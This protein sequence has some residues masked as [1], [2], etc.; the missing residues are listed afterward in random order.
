MSN[1]LN[2]NPWQESGP[3]FGNAYENTNNPVHPNTYQQPIHAPPQP[4]N[5]MPAYSTSG[6]NNAWGTESNKTEYPPQSAYD[7]HNMAPPPMQ[8]NAYQYT[9][10]PYGNPSHQTS[11]PSVTPHPSHHSTKPTGSV[12]PEPWTG[13]VY[14]PPSQ[15]NFWLRFV[16]LLASIG[17]LGFAAGAR[18]VIYIYSYIVI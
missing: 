3:R 4:S 17:H 1:P 12:G 5:Y 15:W 7:G 6:Y 10:T 18:P 13:E 2:E 16:L 14:R 8:P 11:V 9:G